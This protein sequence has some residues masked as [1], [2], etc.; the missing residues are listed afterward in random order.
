MELEDCFRSYLPTLEAIDN[1]ELNILSVDSKSNCVFL[2]Y[3][4]FE[5]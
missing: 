1:F 5:Y 2:N 3:W 4:L